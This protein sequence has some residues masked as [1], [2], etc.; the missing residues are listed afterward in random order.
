MSQT[1]TKQCFWIF[2]KC[3][4]QKLK[5]CTCRCQE[6]VSYSIEFPDQTCKW[7]Q[8]FTAQST[9]T[10]SF[11]D[12]K[13]SSFRWRL[14][15]GWHSD[16]AKTKE[17]WN[18]ESSSSRRRLLRGRVWRYADSEEADASKQSERRQQQ[19]VGKRPESGT[20][21]THVQVNNDKQFFS[22]FC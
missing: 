8:F 16:S 18:G 14:L 11:G 6:N 2:L 9:Q 19:R 17:I 22:K 12:R 3:F 10:K 4:N 15:R 20:Q 7:A 21:T 13:S 5:L 1:K